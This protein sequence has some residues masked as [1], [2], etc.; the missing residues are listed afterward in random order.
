MKLITLQ[1]TTRNRLQDLMKTLELSDEL[2]KDKRLETIICIDG[3][4]PETESILSEKYPQFKIITHPIPIGL[5][6]CRNKLMQ[7]TQTPFA[8]SLDDDLNLLTENNIDMIINW[9][10]AN[11]K[12]AV[13]SFRIYWSLTLPNNFD[14][15]EKTQLVRG[16]AGGAHAFKMEAWKSINSYPEWYIFYG[17]EEYTSMQLFK[18]GWQIH[19]RPEILSHHRVDINSRKLNKGNYIIR[20]LRSYRAGLFNIACFF[21][22]R[23]IPKIYAYSFWNQFKTKTLKGDWKGTLGYLFGIISFIFNLYRLPVY[24]K[25]FSMD[26]FNKYMKTKT[27]PLYW[28]P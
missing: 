6:A 25:R 13:Q 10:V 16:Y 12:C 23:V 9:F 5:I 11:P 2:L 17:E 21:P 15:K 26:E 4:E 24:A 1:I 8:L 14:C 27:V 28:K 20:Q 3:H 7:Q 19:Y 18:K 22:I